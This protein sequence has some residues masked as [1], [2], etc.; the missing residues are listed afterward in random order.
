MQRCDTI[1]DFMKDR[2]HDARKYLG[3][4]G[5][6]GA[7]GA[8]EIVKDNIYYIVVG[9]LAAVMI[10]VISILLIGLFDERVDNDK[11]FSVLPPAFQTIV[12]CFVGVLG[13]RAL[14]GPKPP[15][16]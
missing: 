1:T 7:W 4:I 14:T 15:D 16:A 2:R 3:A 6:I 12:G 10:S 5:A 8:V 11:I 13:G 9:T